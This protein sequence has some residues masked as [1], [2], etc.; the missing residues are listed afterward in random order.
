MICPNCGANNTDGSSFCI[1]CGTN[2]KQIQE[3]LQSQNEQTAT[4]LEQPIIQ[5]NN[6]QYNTQQPMNNSINY[7]VQMQQTISNQAMNNQPQDVNIKN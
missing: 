4:Q 5:Q 7:N 2:L 3:Q 1:K 6:N